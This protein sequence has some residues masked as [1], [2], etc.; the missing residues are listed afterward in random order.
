MEFSLKNALTFNDDV[1]SL[2]YRTSGTS[3]YEDQGVYLILLFA[4]KIGLQVILILVLVFI[5]MKY[6]APCRKKMCRESNKVDVLGIWL[7]RV[8][9]E[10]FL[11]NVNSIHSA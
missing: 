10:Q 8:V 9:H 6:C 11:P 2:L 7:R 1:E 3:I 4:N 5:I